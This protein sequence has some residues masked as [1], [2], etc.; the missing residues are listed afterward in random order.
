MRILQ[1]LVF[2]LIQLPLLVMADDFVW[3]L[4]TTNLDGSTLAPENI[5]KTTFKCGQNPGGPYGILKEASGP[6][7]IMSA[8]FVMSG[9][10]WRYCVA[11]VTN[12]LPQGGEGA[13]SGELAFFLK[14]GAMVAN[15]RAPVAPGGLKL[16]K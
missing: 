9:D 1:A 10:G 13:A 11:T 6:V 7:T 8:D 12:D 3:T 4:P 2:V 14:A 15:P 5:V 16:V